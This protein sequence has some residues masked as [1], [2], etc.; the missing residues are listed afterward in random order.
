MAAQL[1]CSSASLCHKGAAAVG[2]AKASTTHLGQQPSVQHSCVPMQ[3]ADHC[4]GGLVPDTVTS[5]CRLE[6]ALQ[7]WCN[8][9]CEDQLQHVISTHLRSR[10]A[11]SDVKV[12]FCTLLIYLFMLAAASIKTAVAMKLAGDGLPVPSRV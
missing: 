9:E 10:Y 12:I 5:C 7:S 1:L 8:D 11:S 3:Q 6:T 2:L 4:A